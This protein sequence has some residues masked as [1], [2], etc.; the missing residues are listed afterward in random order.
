ML[1]KN[2]GDHEIPFVEFA[3]AYSRWALFAD[4]VEMCPLYAS[5]ARFDNCL[6]VGHDERIAN[7]GAGLAVAYDQEMRK[8]IA[9]MSRCEVQRV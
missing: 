1:E 9:D 3:A 2:R 8:H 6:R 7:R 5:N 4:A